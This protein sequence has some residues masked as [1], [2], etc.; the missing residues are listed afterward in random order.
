[1]SDLGPEEKYFRLKPVYRSLYRAVRAAEIHGGGAG[2][3]PEPPPED[4]IVN[5][6]HTQIR[7]QVAE[8]LENTELS[9]DERRRVLDSIACP[10]CGGTGASFSLSLKPAGI[11]Q[12]G[13]GGF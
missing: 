9:D 1:M 10:C 8:L 13:Q 2:V 4:E 6:V 12:I 5:P 3:A 11:K 7:Q